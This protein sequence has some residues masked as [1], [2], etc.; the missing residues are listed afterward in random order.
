MN[1]DEGVVSAIAGKDLGCAKCHASAAEGTI[2]E[3]K[4]V[5]SLSGECANCH[6]MNMMTE[7]QYHGGDCYICHVTDDATV[8]T[9]VEYQASSCFDCHKMPHGVYMTE[10]RPQ[11]AAAATS[12][13]SS[14][15]TTRGCPHRRIIYH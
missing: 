6:G 7:R 10:R 4:H 5:T 2:H 3:E 12:L 8:V 9:A 1:K 15:S 11:V 13:G 14:R